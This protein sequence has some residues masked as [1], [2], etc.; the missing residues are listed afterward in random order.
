MST[1]LSIVALVCTLSLLVMCSH[2]AP[3]QT[4]NVVVAHLCLDVQNT[5]S[6]TYL[7]GLKGKGG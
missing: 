7:L 3:A 2:A 4:K 6:T 1:K 5:R